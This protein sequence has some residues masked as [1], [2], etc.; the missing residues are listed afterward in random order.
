MTVG[1]IS[2]DILKFKTFLRKKLEE[3]EK[4]VEEHILLG[5]YK[6]YEIN[7]ICKISLRKDIPQGEDILGNG[8]LL[9]QFDFFKAQLTVI[10]EIK[11]NTCLANIIFINFSFKIHLLLP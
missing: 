11:C 2:V 6:L 4:F 7:D 10:N 3:M 5:L 9:N 1:E 8:L